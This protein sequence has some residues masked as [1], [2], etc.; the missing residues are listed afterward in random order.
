MSDR[1]FFVPDGFEVPVELVGDGFRLEPLGEQ[2]N[3]RDLA[4]WSG[5]IAHVRATPGFGDGA[6]PPPEAVSAERNLADL[7]RHARDFAARTGFTYSVLDG[8]DVVGCVYVY[9]GRKDPDRVHVSS[10]VRADRA[11]LDRPLYEAVSRWLAEVWPFEPQR[12]V[13]AAR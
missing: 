2:H 4:A 13:Y 10:W 3:E 8:D 7:A 11:A 5:S 9:P 6:W 1:D 12:I